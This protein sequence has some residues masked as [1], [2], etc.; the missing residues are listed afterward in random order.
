MSPEEG[1]NVDYNNVL[2]MNCGKAD[3]EKKKYIKRYAPGGSGPA[4]PTDNKE[5]TDTQTHNQ[6]VSEF[7]QQRHQREGGAS[8]AIFH[9]L[10]LALALSTRNSFVSRPRHNKNKT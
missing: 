5:R 2:Q 7:Q 1:K 4:L 3:L 6:R 8:R 10:S 9:L